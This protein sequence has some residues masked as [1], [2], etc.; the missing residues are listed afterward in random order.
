M[1]DLL[2]L[3]F[4]FSQDA[5]RLV[6]KAAELGYNVTLGESWRPP[7][8]AALN[9]LKHV[10]VARS[11]HPDRLAIDINLFIGPRYITDDTGHRE[12]GAWWKSL[13]PRHRW[14]GDI[15]H[16]RPDPNHYSI[17]PDGIRA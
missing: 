5:A 11:L 14:G 13:G 2:I 1:S 16:P 10:G 3:Q 15:V 7:E 9:E 4:A 17:T 8:Q 12:L 6:L